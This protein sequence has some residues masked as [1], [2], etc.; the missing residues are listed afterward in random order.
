M[1]LT[2]E[3]SKSENEG[4]DAEKPTDERAPVQRL[5]IWL[6]ARDSVRPEEYV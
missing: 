5:V 3:Q 6:A 2:I 4:V 1:G